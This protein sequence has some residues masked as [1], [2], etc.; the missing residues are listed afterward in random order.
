MTSYMP[1]AVPWRSPGVYDIWRKNGLL[2]SIG[3]I[4]RMNDLQLIASH[5]EEASGLLYMVL[6]NVKLCGGH[7]E[8]SDHSENPTTREL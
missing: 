5:Y 1:S 4:L 6:Y 8:Y 7:F 2:I 3:L